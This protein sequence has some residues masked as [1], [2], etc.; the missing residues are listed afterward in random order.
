MQLATPS[1]RWKASPLDNEVEGGGDN[2]LA[3]GAD[4][5]VAA[6]EVAVGDAGAVAAAEA[7]PPQP[8]VSTGPSG[9]SSTP[10][11]RSSMA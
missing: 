6:E 4:S 10:E 3:E 2:G 7:P 5:G 1:P 9:T 8:R 11:P